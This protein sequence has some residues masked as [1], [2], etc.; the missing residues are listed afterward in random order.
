MTTTAKKAPVRNG[1]R[2]VSMDEFWKDPFIVVE[3]VQQK[4]K[5]L[6]IDRKKDPAFAAQMSTAVELLRAIASRRYGRIS[7]LAALDLFRAAHYFLWL[8]DTEPD[9]H[10]G[11]YKDDAVVFEQVFSRHAAEI[12]EFEEWFRAHS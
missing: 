4:L 9:S 10:N 6:P 12:R 3:T 1:L 7:V 5:A 11:G 2:D 8:G